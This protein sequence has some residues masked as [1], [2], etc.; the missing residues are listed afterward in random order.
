MPQI[1]I[2]I[3]SAVEDGDLIRQRVGD[4]RREYIHSMEHKV[5]ERH[6]FGLETR[7]TAG[8]TRAVCPLRS[9]VV[10][11]AHTIRKLLLQV[12]AGR[13]DEG[14]SPTQLGEFN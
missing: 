8:E 6:N 2:E 1:N 11:H 12:Y 4:V 9:V 10:I 14:T 13:R 5:V 7:T 3:R